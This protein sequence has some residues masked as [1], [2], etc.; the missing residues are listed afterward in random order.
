[1]KTEGLGHGIYCV[2]LGYGEYVRLS[3]GYIIQDEKLV[4]VECGASPSKNRILNALADIGASPKDV[5]AI[6]VTHIH[7][8]HSGGAGYLLDEM[9]R[10]RVL[11]HERG[12]PHLIEPEKLVA[13][14]RMVYGEQ[15]DMFFSPVVPVPKDRVTVVGEGD[16]FE[17]GKER[18]LRFYDAPGHALHHL[19]VYDPVSEGIFTGDAAGVFYREIKEKYDV[20]FC[21]P[22]TTPTQFDPETMIKTM[23]RMLSLKPKHF[24]Y[25]HFGESDKPKDRVEDVK[26]W[27]PVYHNDAVAIYRETKS[28]EAVIGFLREKHQEWLV[29]NGVP[30]SAVDELHVDM[31]VRLNALGIVAY[32]LRLDKQK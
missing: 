22:T 6:I 19:F 3:S 9:T 2:D 29:G 31:D 12:A 10:A 23:D 11:V 26:R 15:F 21:I 14:S 1:M 7:L 25:T 8:D 28:E 4:I 27:L 17:I 13:S 5:D 24:Y 32:A 18:K 16:T 30:K 20:E